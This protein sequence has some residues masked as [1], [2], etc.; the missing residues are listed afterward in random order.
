MNGRLSIRLLQANDIDVIVN[1]FATSS[2]TEK[3]AST[4]QLYLAQ[5]NRLER[6]TWVAYYDSSFAGYITLKWQSEYPFFKEQ[7]IPE[8]KD[9]NVLPNYRN[10]GIGGALLD[11]AEETALKHSHQVGI[12]VGLYPDYGAAQ[13][14]YIKRGYVPDGRGITYEHRTLPAGEN[15]V[16]DDELILWMVKQL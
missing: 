10:Q 6:I 15:I 3:P 16:L 13:R 9:L 1:A 12:G 5:Q 2:W 14:L 8:I 4:F 11:I 7:A